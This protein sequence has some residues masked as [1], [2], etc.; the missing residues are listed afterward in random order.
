MLITRPWTMGSLCFLFLSSHLFLGCLHF[1]TEKFLQEGLAKAVFISL[2][3]VKNVCLVT[4]YLSDILAGECILGSHFL[5]LR[6]L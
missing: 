4:L 2:I 1:F 6:M 3:H 5:S